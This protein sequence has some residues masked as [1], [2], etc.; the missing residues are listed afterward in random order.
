[1][2]QML[3]MPGSNTKTAGPFSNWYVCVLCPLGLCCVWTSVCV[4]WLIDAI[5]RDV[6]LVT[7]CLFF[8]FVGCCGSIPRFFFAPLLS[9]SL[10]L[11]RVWRVGLDDGREMVPSAATRAREKLAHRNSCLMDCI[12]YTDKHY[13]DGGMPHQIQIEL[14][15]AGYERNQSSQQQ[16]SF[17]QFF[18]HFCLAHGNRFVAPSLLCLCTPPHVVLRA[19]VCGRSMLCV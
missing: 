3:P 12:T 10:P 4:Y 6:V 8:C 18:S 9:L 15:V 5:V 11:G 16:S 13:G 2:Q 7:W 17:F 14:P 19:C 1:M